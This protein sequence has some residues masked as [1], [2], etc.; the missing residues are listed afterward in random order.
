MRATLDRVVVTANKRVENI[1]D[2]AA[3]ITVIGERQLENIGASSLADYAA[4]IPGLQIQDNGTPGQTSVTLRGIANLSSGAT[5]ATYIDEVPVGSSGIY[6]GANT[7]MLDV[8]PYDISRVEV[9]RGPQG[10][11]YGAGA[12]GGL[13]KY[14]T[15]APEI[16]GDEFRLGF[17]LRTVAGGAD[18]WN[19][20][21]GASVPLVEDRLGLRISFARNDLPGYT[22]NIVDG[23]KDINGAEQIGARAALFWD[24][25][26]FDLNLSFLEQRINADERGGTALDPVDPEA[27]FWRQRRPDLAAAAVSPKHCPWHR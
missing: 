17:G 14:V 26:A 25:D 11:L 23:R 6:Q 5:V 8:L 13:L 24:G 1:R 27:A 16:S 7:L 4:L 9:L 21:F 12:I 19:A 2:V 18:G 15:R 10:T 3:S 20:R 22:D